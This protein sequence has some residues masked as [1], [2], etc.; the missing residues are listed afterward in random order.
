VTCPSAAPAVEKATFCAIC[1]AACG[2]IATVVDDEV[3]N[4][5]PDPDHPSSRGFACSKG[6]EFHTVLK[7]PDRV[8]VPM[9][10]LPDGTFEP[11]TWKE[12]FD[13][14]GKRLRAVRRAHGTQAIGL[15][16][17]NPIAFNFGG[18][19]ASN[20]F[21]T[22]LK[23]HHQYASSSVDINN[24]HAAG[25]MLYGSTMAYPIPD[26]ASTDFA[27]LLGTNPVVSKGSMMTTGRV[28]DVLVDVVARGGRVVVVDPRRSETASLFEH[29]PIR[30][31]A[32]PWL[33]G[34][35][36]QVLFAEDLIDHA[37]ISAQTSGIEVLRDIAG[38]FDLDRA[39][40]E[41]GVPVE[42]IVELARAAAAASTFAIHGRCGV[43]L[44]QFSTLTKY[45][46]DAVGIVT[47]N[48]DKRGGLVFGDP[49]ADLDA[50]MAKSG[51][52]GRN[53]WFTRV[54]G[55]G[56]INHTAP[57]AVI[58]DEIL[59]PGEGQLR[60]LVTMS[61]NF[62]ASAPDALRSVRALE[63]LDLMISLDPYITE[64]TRHAHWVLPSTLWLERE[65]MPI[66]TQTQAAVPHAQWVRPVVPP[67]GQAR[68]DGWI[69][70]QIARTLGLT[71]SAMPGAQVLGRLGI[72]L[73]P[74]VMIDGVMRAGKHGD[75]FGLRRSGLSRRKLLNHEG[76][77]KLADACEVGVLEEKLFTKDKLVHLAHAELVEE[78]DRLV[79]LGG[80]DPAFPLRLFS[81]RELRSQNSWMHNVPRLTQGD[82]RCR[83][84]ISAQ[85]AE[86]FGI[87]D[88]DVVRL[89]SPWGEIETPVVIS[90]EVMPGSLG[91]TQGWG[92]EGT[93]RR[94][95]AA[96]GANYN[97]L[98]PAD[99]TLIDRPSGNAYLN[100][101]PVR[102]DPV[103]TRGES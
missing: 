12:A 38:R 53:R 93:W 96:G 45:L 60:A 41:S 6:V 54:H 14:I 103:A 49:M 21:V 23:T 27:L 56:E 70:D 47:G 44:G 92:H 15:A 91:F 4:L 35:M 55:I 62:V 8:T 82:R 16:F 81:I 84:I 2:L 85:D 1:E 20:G 37:A 58:A 83:A 46:I 77:V 40:R 76:A 101:I 31:G 73:A 50:I 30:P 61:S 10:R 99:T 59:T 65:Q 51:N 86:G 42:Q 13:D 80:D 74:H 87:R 68:D 63:S 5:R 25:D 72:R 29:V 22:A 24:Y 17:G 33:L 48:L 75:L 19:L 52:A 78:V 28:R 64:T 94:A 69:L 90:D 26:L 102:V 100:G 39:A 43:S 79:A 57:L 97:V 18:G 3:V 89:S 11:A 32:D 36:L 66:F 67:R 9:R 34:A 7:D 88:R 95:V 71:A 98:T